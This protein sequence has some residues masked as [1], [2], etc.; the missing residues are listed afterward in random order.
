VNC[1]GT[2]HSAKEKCPGAAGGGEDGVWGMC[3]SAVPT[4]ILDEGPYECGC[5]GT[6]G[7]VE[8]KILR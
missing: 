6:N 2:E 3:A 1:S 5:V 4:S 7:K 8:I